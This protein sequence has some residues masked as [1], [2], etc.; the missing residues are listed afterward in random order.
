MLPLISRAGIVFALIATLMSAALRAQ[1]SASASFPQR[2]HGFWLSVGLGYGRLDFSCGGG[3]D[4]WDPTPPAETCPEA[5]RAR[6]TLLFLRAGYALSQ[7][8]LISVSADAWRRVGTSDGASDLGVAVRGYP[9]RSRGLFAEAGVSRSRF[10][11][12]GGDGPDETGE[13]VGLVAGIG[14]DLRVD[15][16]MS[17]SPVI[18]LHYGYQGDTGIPTV[19]HFPDGSRLALRTRVHETLVTFGL[20][21]TFH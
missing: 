21:L 8:V 1:D 19:V 16:N 11:V 2:R 7:Q 13:G 14:W 20:A 4:P 15:T 5:G 12:P 9:V 10:R 3:T 17:L 18:L 6:A